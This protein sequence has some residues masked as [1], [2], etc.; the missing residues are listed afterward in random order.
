MYFY[1]I[2]FHGKHPLILLVTREI[3]LEII[4]SNYTDTSLLPF[5]EPFPQRRTFWVLDFAFPLFL[6][7]PLL[8]DLHFFSA[9]LFLTHGCIN[10]CISLIVTSLCPP[11]S[12]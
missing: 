4:A 3:S 7:S 1:W 10:A 6:A 8:F 9:Y 5:T 11:F 2:A 12:I